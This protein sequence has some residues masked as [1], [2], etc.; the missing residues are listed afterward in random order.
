MINSLFLHMGPGFHAKIENQFFA[1]AHPHIVFWDQPLVNSF[2][3]LTKATLHKIEEIYSSS[4]AP[5][6]LYAHSFGGQLA[7]YAVLNKPEIIGNIKMLNSAF[8]PFECFLNLSELEENTKIKIRN[9]AT[10]EKMQLIFSLASR[11][12]FPNLYWKS[13][14]KKEQ[15]DLAASHFTNLDVTTFAQVFSSFLDSKYYNKL[16]NKGLNLPSSWNKSVTILRSVEDNL[17]KKASDCDNWKTIFKSANI[18]D[19]LNSGHYS[20]FDSPETPDLFFK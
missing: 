8:D 17:I 13:L 1:K 11:Q 9:S 6:N 7:L 2:E 20:L 18:V 16:L 10:S 14:Q 4:K 3:D 5:V 15:Y 12:D 19:I